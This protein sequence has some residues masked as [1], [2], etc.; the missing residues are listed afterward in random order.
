MDNT[1]LEKTESFSNFID[2]CKELAK[3]CRLEESLLGNKKGKAVSNE[4]VQSF[5]L[6]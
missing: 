2:I 6:L 5:E 4:V 3:A 1:V